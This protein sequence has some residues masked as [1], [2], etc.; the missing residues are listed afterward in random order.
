MATPRKFQLEPAATVLFSL[1][2][3]RRPALFFTLTAW[4]L[5]TG[6]QWDFVQVFAWSRMFTTYAQTMPLLRAAER[7]FSPDE[8][9]GVCRAVATAKQQQSREESTVPGGKASGKHLL[10]CAPRTLVFLTPAPFCAGLTPA[11][12][13]PLSAERATPPNPPPRSLA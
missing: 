2:M 10:V 5:A 8:M 6:C 4:L 12:S 11:V 3:F 1:F 7:T 9:C 13:T